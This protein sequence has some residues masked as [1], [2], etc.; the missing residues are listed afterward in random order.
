M[1]N[2]ENAIR[3]IRCEEEMCNIQITGVPEMKRE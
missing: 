1:K 3:N 2:T